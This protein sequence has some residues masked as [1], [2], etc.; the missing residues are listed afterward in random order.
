MALETEKESRLPGKQ[1]VLEPGSLH[2]GVEGDQAVAGL[3][4]SVNL[5][6]WEAAQQ[7]SIGKQPI[8]FGTVSAGS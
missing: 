8:E 4:P 1:T 6:V 3:S 7:Q 2:V 5:W